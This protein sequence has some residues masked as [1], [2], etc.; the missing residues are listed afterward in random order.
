MP[1]NSFDRC[2]ADE[3]WVLRA[4]GTTRHWPPFATAALAAPTRR[5][6]HTVRHESCSYERPTSWLVKQLVATIYFKRL[7]AGD[8][9]SSTAQ[10]AVDGRMPERHNNNNNNINILDLT[11]FK[12]NEAPRRFRQQGELWPHARHV[13]RCAV[14]CRRQSKIL[15]EQ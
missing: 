6:I 11:T 1:C 4:P 10:S 2:R 7:S 13:H 8:R 9:C 5:V 15:T 14:K 3:T 12:S